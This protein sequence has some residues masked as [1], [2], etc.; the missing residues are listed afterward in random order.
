MD[1]TVYDVV[2]INTSAGKDSQTM[3]RYVANLAREQGVLGRCLAVHAALGRVEWPG[4]VELA[5]LQAAL[6]GVRFATITRAQGNL[7]E[8]VEKR[9]MWPS[10]RQR[11]CTS[12]H[13][14]AQVSKIITKHHGRILNCLGMRAE[15]SPARAK[16]PVLKR[17]ERLTTKTRWVYDGLPIH[18]W[19]E[20]QVWADIRASKI[21]Y[22]PA[23]DLGMQNLVVFSNC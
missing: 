22:H 11:Y 2:I 17:N 10:P 15:E 19:T 20:A 8:H 13:K 6:N 1:L 21:P 16:L 23:Y 18:D 3:L 7:L 12:D 5:H 4:V 9:G 14:R